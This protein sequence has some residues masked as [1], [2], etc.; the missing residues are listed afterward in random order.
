MSPVRWSIAA[1]GPLAA[2]LIWLV[3]ASIGSLGVDAHMWHAAALGVVMTAVTILGQTAVMEAYRRH[4]RRD[5]AEHTATEQRV[6]GRRMSAIETQNEQVLE[7]LAEMEQLL[8]RLAEMDRRLSTIHRRLMESGPTNQQPKGV[9]RPRGRS[10]KPGSKQP[11]GD[12]DQPPPPEAESAGA[13]NLNSPEKKRIFARGFAQGVAARLTG[14]AGAGGTVYPF[15]P[16][17]PE[18]PDDQAGE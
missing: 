3:T 13:L 16:R 8:K 18:K 7:R 12:R 14:G 11:G 6:L 1:L 9:R 17:E 10:T 15:K 4:G 2:Y 5:L